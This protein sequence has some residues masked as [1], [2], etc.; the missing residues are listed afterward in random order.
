MNYQFRTLAVV[1]LVALMYIS[2]PAQTGGDFVVKQSVIAGGGGSGSGGGFSVRST[3][4][5]PVAGDSASGGGFSA[6]SGFWT[7]GAA[8]STGVSISGRVLTPTGL[9]LR[10]AVVFIVDSQCVQRTAT[11][12]SFGI[13]TFE[14][15]STGT[16]YTM[17]VRS[18]RYRFG[19][20]TVNVISVMTDI[21]FTGLE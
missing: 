5:Q 8:V 10:N 2:A 14:N 21:D 15:V 7:S 20:R 16:S 17:G 4:G 19:S 9:G 6:S 11:T 1:F 12:S 13:Y 3:I 18:K